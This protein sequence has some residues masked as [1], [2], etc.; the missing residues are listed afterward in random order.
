M[1]VLLLPSSNTTDIASATALL[2]TF[3]GYDGNIIESSSE[4]HGAQSQCARRV[5]KYQ[6]AHAP[7]PIQAVVPTI[8]EGCNHGVGDSAVEGKRRP[9][10]ASRALLVFHGCNDIPR[11]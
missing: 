6:T 2:T 1:H 10:L 4:R 8:S 7:I 5:A 11:S 9:L 3:I